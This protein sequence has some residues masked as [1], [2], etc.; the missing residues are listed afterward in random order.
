MQK[1][2]EALVLAGQ[3]ENW[4]SCIYSERA[5]EHSGSGAEDCSWESLKEEVNV[6]TGHKCSCFWD[7][8]AFRKNIQKT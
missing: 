6:L 8:L 2:H 1:Y 7:Q 4:C 5:W 3:E